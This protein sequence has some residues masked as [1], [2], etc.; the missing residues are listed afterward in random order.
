MKL[1]KE[2]KIVDNKGHTIIPSN[3]ETPT[4]IS[5]HNEFNREY[6]A[7]LSNDLY[8]HNLDIS[9]ETIDEDKSNSAFERANDYYLIWCI[10]SDNRYETFKDC[11]SQLNEL[12]EPDTSDYSDIET[13]YDSDATQIL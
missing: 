6:M 10:L 4:F 5:L 9:E 2:K 1:L 3:I 8:N 7:D 11:I 12:I 13:D